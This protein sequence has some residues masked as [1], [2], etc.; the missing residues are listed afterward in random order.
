MIQFQYVLSAKNDV[1]YPS[2]EENTDLPSNRCH[3]SL[4]SVQP[5]M[6]QT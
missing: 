4:N 2:T 5:D 3:T 6:F 1:S